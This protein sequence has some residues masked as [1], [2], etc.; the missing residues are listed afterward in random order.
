MDLFCSDNVEFWASKLQGIWN[1][2]I[3][4]AVI[5]HKNQTLQGLELKTDGVRDYNLN[6]R[7]YLK[8]VH[9]QRV[10]RMGTHSLVE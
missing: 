10:P 1:T 6:T 7:K 3:K 5:D 2:G 4:S 8:K 9:L